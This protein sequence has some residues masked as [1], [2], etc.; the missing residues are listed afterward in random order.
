MKEAEADLRP[1]NRGAQSV[2]HRHC[3]SVTDVRPSCVQD[4]GATLLQQRQRRRGEFLGAYFDAVRSHHHQQSSG[5]RR[6]YPGPL[7]ELP[8]AADPSGADPEHDPQ[9]LW[10]PVL[11]TGAMLGLCTPDTRRSSSLGRIDRRVPRASQVAEA[12][13][14][15]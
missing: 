13:A 1:E 6:R 4:E 2:V 5:V 15:S 10:T 8:T 11:R 9:P 3:P 14:V 12:T 7:S